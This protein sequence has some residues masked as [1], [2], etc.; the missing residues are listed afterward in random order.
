MKIIA[1]LG[2]P[3]SEYENTRHNAGFKVIDVL[4]DR[5]DIPIKGFENHCLTGKGMIEGE[6]VFLIK[7]QTYMNLSGVA[8]RAMLDYYDKTPGDLIVIYDDI[9]LSTGRLRVR[10]KGSAGGHNGIKNIIN[11]LNVSEFDRVRVGVGAKPVGGDLINWVLG[12][13]PA[14]EIPVMEEAYSKAADA[15]ADIVAGGVEH[16]MNRYNG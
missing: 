7:P 15:V 8:V 10:S 11:Q 6:K 9:D 13:F 3:G 12:H 4:S 14:E 1:G 16:A 2:N 5:Y